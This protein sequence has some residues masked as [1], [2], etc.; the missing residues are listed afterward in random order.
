MMGKVEVKVNTLVIADHTRL[1][2]WQ[3]GPICILNTGFAP[4]VRLHDKHPRSV[5]FGTLP[6]EPSVRYA[7]YEHWICSRGSTAEHNLSNKRCPM[8][9]SVRYR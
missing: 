4:V 7:R 8:E 1:I 9:L 6:T 3:T 5:L 2:L